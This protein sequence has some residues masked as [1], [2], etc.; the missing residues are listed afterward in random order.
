MKV[1]VEQR[2]LSFAPALWSTVSLV[3]RLAAVQSHCG[4]HSGGMMKQLDEAAW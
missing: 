1:H 3:T 4:A 2:S